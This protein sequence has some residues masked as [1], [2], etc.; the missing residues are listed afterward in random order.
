MFLNDRVFTSVFALALLSVYSGNT[1]CILRS[2][3]YRLSYYVKHFLHSAWHKVSAQCMS[4][5]I[6]RSNSFLIPAVFQAVN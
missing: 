5:S 6:C 2:L 3:T 4:A 1:S